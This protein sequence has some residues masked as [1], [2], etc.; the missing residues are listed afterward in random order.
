MDRLPSL[1]VQREGTTTALQTATISRRHH[2]NLISFLKK[3]LSDPNPDAEEKGAALD[4]LSV[5]AM[6]DPNLTRSG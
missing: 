6:H 3:M 4:F 5:I 1:S 2:V